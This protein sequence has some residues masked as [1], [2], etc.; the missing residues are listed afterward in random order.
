MATLRWDDLQTFLHQQKDRSIIFYVLDL[1]SF[2]KADIFDL[3]VV[4]T[5]NSPRYD[6]HEIYFNS[7]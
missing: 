5:I 3:Q 7:S 6:E 2:E 1:I 4:F